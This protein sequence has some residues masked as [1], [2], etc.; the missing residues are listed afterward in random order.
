MRTLTLKIHF[1]FKVKIGRHN[2]KMSKVIIGVISLME[3][4]LT[5]LKTFSINIV[6]LISKVKK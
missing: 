1:T 3:M 5:I 4:I 2:K 6:R